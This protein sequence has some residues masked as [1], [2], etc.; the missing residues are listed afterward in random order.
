VFS[1]GVAALQCP[2]CGARYRTDRT[3]FDDWLERSN[4]S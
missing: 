4:V 1:E 3:M 2:R